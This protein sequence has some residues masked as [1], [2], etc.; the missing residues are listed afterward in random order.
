MPLPL[1]FIGI[2]AAAGLL[3]LGKG[4]KAGVDFTDAKKANLKAQDILDAAK[5]EV[6]FAK[7]A[8]GRGLMALGSK[9]VFIIEKSMKRFIESFEKIKNIEYQES[10]ALEE[11]NK[12]ILDKETFS[13][14]KELGNY[15]VSLLGGSAAGALGGALTAFGAYSAATLLA[16]A[17]TG[18]AIATLSGVAATNATL[19]FFGGGALAVGG[20]GMA[21]GMIVLGSLVLGP[22]LA[23]TGI[24]T[25]ALASKELNKAK[26]NI[27][28]ARKTAEELSLIVVA[29]NG[30]RRRAHLFAR[31]LI[32]LDSI[33]SPFVFQMEDIIKNNGT[34]FA[35]YSQ[36]DKEII[37]LTVS[38]AVAIKS[39]LDTPILSEEGKLTDESAQIAEEVKSGYEN[40]N[41]QYGAI[42]MM[43]DVQGE[44]TKTAS[45]LVGMLNKIKRIF[46]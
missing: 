17:S 3:G 12:F 31:L 10:P 45:P 14:L 37:S 27:A 5:M 20:L 22:A 23:I 39:I 44:N 32:R 29:C 41:D 33:F 8:S 16:S 36:K 1:L 6:D 15:V 24:I 25:G 11:L 26:S 19:A 2:G 43:N 4:I 40:L 46:K 42:H 34:N 28:E 30:I 9:K 13:E 35:K 38:T 21:G 7:E 18:T